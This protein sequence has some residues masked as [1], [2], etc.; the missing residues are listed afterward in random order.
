MAAAVASKKQSPTGT[1]PTAASRD[2]RLAR[3][4][5]AQTAR[6]LGA[7][8]PRAFYDK[9][10]KS[11][12]GYLAARFAITPAGMTQENVRKTLSERGVSSATIQNLLSVWQTC[13]QALFAA[14]PQAAQMEHTWRMAESVVQ[15]LEKTG[16]K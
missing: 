7:G 11:M 6:L 10:F 13:E 12:Q 1:L 3:E 4:S 15:D 5:F 9:L 16:G 8:N 14:Q 2:V